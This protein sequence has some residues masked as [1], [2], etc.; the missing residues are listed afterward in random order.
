MVVPS[1]QMYKHE[2]DDDDDDDED[3]ETLRLA[4]LKSLKAKPPPS[5][6]KASGQATVSQAHAPFPPYNKHRGGQRD[7]Y[8]QNWPGRQNGVSYYYV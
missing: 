1:S 3:L 5:I 2:D 6:T 7:F 8:Y 4:A